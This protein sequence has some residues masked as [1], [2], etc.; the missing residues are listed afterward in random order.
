M[1]SI[2]YYFE[3]QHH[4]MFRFGMTSRETLLENDINKV[5]LEK[6]D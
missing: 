2:L 4:E 5:K 6:R 3:R 1:I